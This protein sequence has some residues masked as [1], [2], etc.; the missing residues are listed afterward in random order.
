MAKTH[1]RAARLKR[2]KG[3]LRRRRAAGLSGNRTQMSVNRRMITSVPRSLAIPIPT[4][5]RFTMTASY[6]EPVNIAAGQQPVSSFWWEAFVPALAAGDRAQANDWVFPFGFLPFMQV[7]SR[8]IVEKVT[9]TYRIEM[10]TDGEQSQGEFTYGFAPL[11]RLANFPNLLVSYESM[12]A[13]PF[14]K[15]ASFSGTSGGNSTVVV[16]DSCEVTKFSGQPDLIQTNGVSRDLLGA[17]DF[18]NLL[19]QYVPAAQS[20]SQP[21]FYVIMYRSG[22]A[23][24]F[25]AQVSVKA[26][27]T[28]RFMDPAPMPIHINEQ[29]AVNWAW[30]AAVP[31]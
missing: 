20:L 8:C 27:F 14:A 10:K 4:Q 13:L 25:A 17:G 31:T 15:R 3:L 26:D 6:S 30:V 16:Q 18:Y 21:V 9:F 7:Y 12:I 23:A 28:V 24:A 22:N 2:L 11:S 29:N 5:Q 19:L 1:T